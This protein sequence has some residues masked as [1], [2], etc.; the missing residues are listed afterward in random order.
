MSVDSISLP[1]NL[2]SIQKTNLITNNYFL[3]EQILLR[4]IKNQEGNISYHNQIGKKKYTEIHGRSHTTLVHFPDQ[5]Q[6]HSKEQIDNFVHFFF[7]TKF[8]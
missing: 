1:I 5:S 3:K 2:S 4:K 6:Q 8:Y 7:K